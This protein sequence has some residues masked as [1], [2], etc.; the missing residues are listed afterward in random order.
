[1]Q[2]EI[3]QTPSKS[4]V[5]MQIHVTVCAGNEQNRYTCSF[6]HKYRNSVSYIVIFIQRRNISGF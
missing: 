4:I 1:M 5:I 6:Y 3:T 2:F